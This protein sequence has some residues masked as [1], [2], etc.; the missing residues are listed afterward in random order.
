MSGAR[1]TA[2]ISSSVGPAVFGPSIGG[3]FSVTVSAPGLD[4]L[5]AQLSEI[6]TT[7]ERALDREMEEEVKETVKRI[8]VKW[9]V[10]TGRSRGLGLWKG[11]G[12]QYLRAGVLIYRI[13]NPQP[14]TPYVRKKGGSVPLVDTLVAR[15]VKALRARITKSAKALLAKAR[16]RNKKPKTTR[17]LSG[18][19]RL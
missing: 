6:S 3:G 16:A 8:Q 18:R 13:V 7:M 4:K 19:I 2:P 11:L 10:L 12:W 9:P 14:Y 5:L 15:E 17:R 1:P